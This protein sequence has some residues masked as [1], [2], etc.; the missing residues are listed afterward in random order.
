[1]A[2]Y[3]MSSIPQP[4][5][6][7][8]TAGAMPPPRFR[9]F[10]IAVAWLA[11]TVVVSISTWEFAYRRARDGLRANAAVQLV[12]DAGAVQSALEK[13]ETLP[14]LMSL[15]PA[16]AYGLLHPNS[17]DDV[18]ALDRY[19]L[20]I[21]QRARI[22]AAYVVQADGLTIAASNYGSPQT[23]VGNN[24]RFR[25]YVQS[26]I[27]GS[28][29]RFYGIGTTTAEPGYFLAQ[30][31]LAGPAPARV[32]GAVVIKLDLQ[33]FEKSWPAGADPVALVDANGVVFLSNVAGWKYRSI[34]PL[35]AAAR[36]EIR[37][38]QQYTGKDIDRVLATGARWAAQDRVI[39]PVGVLGWRLIRFVSVEGARRA[40]NSAAVAAALSLA[41]AGLL[42]LVVDQRRRHRRIAAASRRALERASAQLEQR[43]AERTQE[44]VRANDDL[45]QRYR[46]MHATERLLRETQSELVQA[47]KLAML[48]Q[49]AAGMTHELNQPLTALRV[50][51]DNA[52][53]FLDRGDAP[54]ARENLGHITSAAT[55]MGR[56]IGQLK[57]FARKS[58]GTTWAVDL[59]TSIENSAL[60]LR[61]D[62]AEAD[63]SLEVHIQQ[64]A[65]VVGDPIRV[66]QVLINLMR[67][68]LDA[69]R[70]CAIRRVVVTLSAG[71]RA[72][73][74][75][76]DSGPGITPQV[77]EH[78][79]E[80]FFT[81]KLSGAGLGLGLAI[82]ASI[83]QA[84]NGELVVSDGDEGGATFTLLLPL[85]EPRSGG[86]PS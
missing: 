2:S 39:Q 86:D 31:V 72:V 26:A 57:G 6:L 70:A 80:P 77:R 3:A 24:Y 83:V 40:A 27:Q 35:S 32:I 60:L 9:H 8:H 14:F 52:I 5:G 30:P 73:L 18:E 51:A 78:L 68:A 69:V 25:P 55:R 71:D 63:A 42:A 12:A 15:Q 34:A 85:V 11:A 23:F 41:I 79:F 61:S 38:T 43:I 58:P 65:S 36:E 45:E 62:F 37:L 20:E 64:A 74:R 81:T 17:R 4:G 28:T 82:S 84:M 46:E 76:A 53:A 33:D 21:Q 66:E 44:L 47:G 1:M 54:S 56:L 59:A 75:I 67:N 48:G 7:P 13:F 50:F 22:A 49:M 19:L 29:G 16:V 10:A